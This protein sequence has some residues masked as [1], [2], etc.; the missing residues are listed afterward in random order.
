M[1]P[2]CKTC[3]GYLADCDLIVG[4][5]SCVECER[6]PLLAALREAERAKSRGQQQ[7]SAAR[8]GDRLKVEAAIRQLAATGRPFSANQARAIHGVKG[9]VVG[10]AFTALH[11]A[12]V[13]EPC[14]DETSTDVGTHGHRIYQ[15]RGVQALARAG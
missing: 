1:N 4:A 8:P 11:K 10:A 2:P 12:R 9:G 6:R 7:A 3:L 5:T 14:G 13:I 15:W